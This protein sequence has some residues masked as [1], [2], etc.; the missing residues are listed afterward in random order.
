MNENINLIVKKKIKNASEEKTL[1]LVRWFAGVCLVIT[2]GTSVLFFI[3]T[4]NPSL[5]VIKQQENNTLT[6]LSFTQGKVA[7]YFLIKDRLTTI[8][9][10]LQTR[11]RIDQTLAALEQQMPD[12]VS[13]ISMDIENK[14]ASFML[15]SPNL[16]SLNTTVTNMTSL[17]NNKKIVKKVTLESITADQKVESYTLSFKADLL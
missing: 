2:L 10:I 14:T 12:D 16:L 11:Y 13:V 8:A 9:Q 6:N 5:S 7:K 3:L 1:L 17:L 15:S 4:L